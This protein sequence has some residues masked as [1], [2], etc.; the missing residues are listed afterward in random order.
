[1]LSLT[2]KHLCL[3]Q[4]PTTLLALLGIIAVTF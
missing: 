3:S 1:M 4:N 2:L